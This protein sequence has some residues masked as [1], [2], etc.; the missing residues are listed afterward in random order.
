MIDTITSLIRTVGLPVSILLLVLYR[1]DHFVNRLFNVFGDFTTSI[2][3]LT[4]EIKNLKYS[5]HI[6]DPPL[7]ENY[8]SKCPE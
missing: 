7:H 8:Q 3:N 5:I 2:D 4:S 6:K 1:V